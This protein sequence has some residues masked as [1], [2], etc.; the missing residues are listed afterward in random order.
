MENQAASR[1]TASIIYPP[2][3]D[4]R[5]INRKNF[6]KIN[7]D[8]PAQSIKQTKALQHE[9]QPENKEA[10]NHFHFIGRLYERLTEE[11]R[12]AAGHRR[13]VVSVRSGLR[14]VADATNG[15]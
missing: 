11:N 7:K 8:F 3:H 15:S 6:L 4:T 12:L 13:V 1:F 5:R 10:H 9:L 2:S 14:R